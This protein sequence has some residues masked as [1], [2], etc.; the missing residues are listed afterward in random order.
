MKTAK[1]RIL[2]CSVTQMAS[3]T[4]RRPHTTSPKGKEPERS[5]GVDQRKEEHD[6]EHD[7]DHDH[8]HAEG[9]EHSHSH[10]HSVLSSFGHAH[11][12]GEGGHGDADQVMAALTGRGALLDMANYRPEA[13]RE[14]R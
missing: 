12:H 11:T 9:H 14:T 3:L 10:S 4:S 8:T 7:H 13:D 2:V 5:R 6:R 1:A